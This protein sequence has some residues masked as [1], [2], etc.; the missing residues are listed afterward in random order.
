M[1]DN[2]LLAIFFT[3]LFVGG[4]TCMTVQGGL[5]ATTIAQKTEEQ[6]REK[7][8][9]NGYAWPLLA[10][11]G[12]K[13]LV[14][15]ILG[16]FLGWL[17]SFFQ[18]SIAAQ[19]I[20]Q[21]AV[22]I[23]MVGA[24]MNLLNVHPV[25]RYFVFQPPKFLTRLVRN[26]AK[27]KDMF[28]PAILGA[29]TIFIPCGMTQAMMAL[30]IA[31]G[32]PLLGATI[33]FVFILGTSPIFFILGYLATRLGD[34]LQARFAK[35]AAIALMGLALFNLNNAVA[36]TGITLSPLNTLRYAYCT[37][38]FC[39]DSPLLA[40]AGGNN[41]L[42]TTT[43]NATITF[44]REGYT[45]GQITVKGGS[46]VTLTLVNNEGRGCVQ[47]FTIPKLGIQK[48]VPVGTSQTIQFTAPSEPGKLAFMCSMGMYRG[49]INII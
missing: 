7:S 1:D 21:I 19:I 44:N 37:I 32:N 6:L 26:Q 38:S 9:Q 16:V 5:L 4:L 22:A 20:L 2:N 35:I 15:T 42:G 8:R 3:G 34:V 27:S 24:A 45:P 11:L 46:P 23:F 48:I 47:T 31:S 13:L 18:L 39:D 12:S 33:M 41:V 30:A 10:F 40:R 25:F 43:N 17:G 28:A 29:F 36:L 14:Y 49:V